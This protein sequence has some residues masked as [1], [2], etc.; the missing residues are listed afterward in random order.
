MYRGDK[1]SFRST[2][3]TAMEARKSRTYIKT[4]DPVLDMVGKGNEMHGRMLYNSYC[5]TCHQRDGKGDNNR[6]PP[7][8][9]SPYLAGDKEQLINI[10][11]NG[12]K[13]KIS[14][15]GKTFDGVMP[16]HGAFLDDQSIASI[17]AYI[18]DRFNNEETSV[19]A[20]MVKKVRGK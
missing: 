20:E 9:G 1:K 11:L 7:L 2:Q 3:L 10:V 17:V 12:L 18:K 15:N 14:V 16:A 19:T 5:A 13:G 8:A 4:P 6:Y